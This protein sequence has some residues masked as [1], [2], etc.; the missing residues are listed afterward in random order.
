MHF[1]FYEFKSRILC[2]FSM[3]FHVVFHLYIHLHSPLHLSSRSSIIHHAYIHLSS[4]TRRPS[5][6][7]QWTYGPKY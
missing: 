5:S 4:V 3:A 6:K 7:E 2:I 1:Q